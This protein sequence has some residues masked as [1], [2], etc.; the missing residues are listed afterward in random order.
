MESPG[1]LKA[2]DPFNAIAGLYLSLSQYLGLVAVLLLTKGKEA[3]F[4]KRMD[5]MVVVAVVVVLAL[6]G[7]RAPILFAIIVYGLYYLNSVHVITFTLKTRTVWWLGAGT[8]MAILAFILMLQFEST[9]TLISRS[10]GRFTS[11]FDGASAEGSTDDSTGDRILFIQQS[12]EGI[13]HNL[14]SFLFG[15]GI[16]SF[17]IITQGLDTRYYPH[18]MIL[19]IWFELGLV[20][21]SLL[22]V[23]IAYLLLELRNMPGRLISYWLLLYIFLNLMKS[24]SLVDIRVEFA[25]LALFTVQNYLVVKARAAIGDVPS[26]T[27]P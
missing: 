26:P 21:V 7:A 8:V 17:G 11:L 27:L 3:I 5:I 22:V 20:G 2:E 18:N 1:G 9:A 24:S 12:F 13:F 10:V 23:W 25:F 6:L 15:Y 16:G 19:E 14:R 4:S